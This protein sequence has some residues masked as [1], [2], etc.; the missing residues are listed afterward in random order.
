MI[1]RRRPSPLHAARAGVSALWCLMLGVAALSF[2][3]PLLLATLLLVTLGAAA[4]AGVGRAVARSLRWAVPFALVL[5]EFAEAPGF[6]LLGR[7]HG[8]AI[9]DLRVGQAVTL[10]FDEGPAGLHV[11][12]FSPVGGDA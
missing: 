3:H 4:A 8:D 1:H 11:P 12:C 5:A 9:H 7:M 6:R 10:G 2:E